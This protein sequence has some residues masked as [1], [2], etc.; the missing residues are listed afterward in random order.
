MVMEG[1]GIGDRGN[2]RGDSIGGELVV[3]QKVQHHKRAGERQEDSN[4]MA[5]S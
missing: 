4:L 5:L 2:N 1:D 3:N